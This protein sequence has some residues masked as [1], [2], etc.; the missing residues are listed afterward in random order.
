MTAA[1]LNDPGRPLEIRHLLREQVRS[2]ASPDLGLQPDGPA[3]R[4]ARIPVR[5]VVWGQTPSDADNGEHN[6]RL[7]ISADLWQ[8]TEVKQLVGGV[9]PTFP[10]DRAHV[11]SGAD[12]GWSWV[13]YRTRA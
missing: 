8:I 12:Y 9:C 3:E 11:A 5:L 1:A 13:A 6:A 10:A 7:Y 2:G 4:R